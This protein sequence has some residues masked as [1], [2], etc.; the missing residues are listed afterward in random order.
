MDKRKTLGAFGTVAL[1]LGSI[2]MCG[3]MGIVVANV[4]GRVLLGQ[5]VPGTVEVAGLGGLG[6]VAIALGCVT[7]RRS[8]IVVR[9]LADRFPLRLRGWADALTSTISLAALVVLAIAIG[10]DVIYAASYAQETGVLKIPTVPF[11]VVWCV[12]VVSLA[13]VVLRDILEGIR[14]GL[15][16]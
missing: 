11:K 16:K 10:K 3:V 6:V 7:W 2:C 1:V 5:P 9:I 4:I 12:G 14:K 8:N 15:G 13:L